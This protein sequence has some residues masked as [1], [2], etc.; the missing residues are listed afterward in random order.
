MESGKGPR[1]SIPAGGLVQPRGSMCTHQALP[2]L[3]WDMLSIHTTP[4]HPFRMK[5]EL[6]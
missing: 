1:V 4:T 3:I 6:W 5:T 2:P